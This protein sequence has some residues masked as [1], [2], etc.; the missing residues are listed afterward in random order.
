MARRLAPKRVYIAFRYEERT[1]KH[2]LKGQLRSRNSSARISDFSLKERAATKSW[3][4]KAED[5]IRQ[6]SQ[7]V[8]VAGPT[9][10]NSRGVKAEVRIARRLNKPICQIRGTTK[11]RCPRVPGAGRYYRWSHANLGKVFGRGTM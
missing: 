6:A 8:V 2:C 11:K 10:H 9:A 7:V 5:R 3:K 4:K 1:L